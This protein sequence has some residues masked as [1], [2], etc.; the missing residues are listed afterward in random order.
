MRL[1]K[2]AKDE[3]S[4]ISGCQ[5]L[6]LAENGMFGIQGIEADAD[7]MGNVENL[8]PGEG[9]VFIKPEIVIEAVRRYQVGR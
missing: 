3:D 5:A 1:E 7:T 8:L 9:V 4:K 6:Y 2:L